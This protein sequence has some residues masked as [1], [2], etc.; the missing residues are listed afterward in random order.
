MAVVIGPCLYGFM[1]DHAQEE[2]VLVH[3]LYSYKK[4][5]LLNILSTGYEYFKV[6][7]VLYSDILYFA[8]ADQRDKVCFIF[9]KVQGC[10]MEKNHIY[11]VNLFIVFAPQR[12]PEGDNCIFAYQHYTR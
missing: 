9:H 6:S 11:E 8:W 12:I 10:C 2:T 3:I 7:S 4:A 1:L 5:R